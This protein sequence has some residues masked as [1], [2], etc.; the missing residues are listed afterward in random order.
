[1]T[2]QSRTGAFFAEDLLPLCRSMVFSAGCAPHVYCVHSVFP[3]NRRWLCI[4]QFEFKDKLVKDCNLLNGLLTMFCR[5]PV[6]RRLYFLCRVVL[7][8]NPALSKATIDKAMNYTSAIPDKTDMNK[9]KFLS[10]AVCRETAAIRFNTNSER[11]TPV[12][13][14]WP[15]A[16]RSEGRH[17][18]THEMIAYTTEENKFDNLTQ[19]DVSLL[20]WWATSI[21]QRKSWATGPPPPAKTSS[22]RW[23]SWGQVT[24]ISSKEINWHLSAAGVK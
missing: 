5:I 11:R 19:D 8:T 1:M 4:L 3:D 15:A 21:L 12:F 24:L 22:S 16:F 23:S 18:V 13:C 6:T 2:W 17:Q 20:W 9:S 10:Y 7:C 14:M